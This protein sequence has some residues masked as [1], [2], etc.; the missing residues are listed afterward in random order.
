MT[1]GRLSDVSGRVGLLVAGLASVPLVV[2]VSGVVAPVP[3]GDGR[4]LCR[5]VVGVAAILTSSIFLLLIS[6]FLLTL[7]K[8]W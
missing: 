4:V 5:G 2:V 6:L 3:A 1:R 7:S 8:R